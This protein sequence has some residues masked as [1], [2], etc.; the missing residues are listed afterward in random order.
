MG[1]ARLVLSIEGSEF[2]TILLLRNLG[3][4]GAKPCSTPSGA[5]LG[6]SCHHTAGH[7]LCGHPVQG[8]ACASNPAL[9]L[10]EVTPKCPFRGKEEVWSTCEEGRY[11]ENPKVP[12]CD[13]G[14]AHGVQVGWLSLQCVSLPHPSP[15]HSR[16]QPWGGGGG[17]VKRD[18]PPQGS[19]VI[20]GSWTCLCDDRC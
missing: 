15:V 13:A 18:T 4:G 1:P 3:P 9:S 19:V 2:K 20:T 6:E 14:S 10:L 11:K 5:T 8:R 7:V 12:E 16:P 17:D